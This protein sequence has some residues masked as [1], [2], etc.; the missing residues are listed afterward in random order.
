[1]SNIQ[2]TLQTIWFTSQRLLIYCLVATQMWHCFC[3]NNTHLYVCVYVC[4]ICVCVC[5]YVCMYMC[6]CMYVCMCIMY[7]C[8]YVC[9]CVYVCVYVCMYVYYVCMYVCL[10]IIMYVCMYMYYVCMYVRMYVY[11][12]VCTVGYATTNQCYNEQFLSIKSGCYN[13]S[14]GI[15]VLSADVARAC[16]WH[17]EA[18]R[19]DY[20]VSHHPCY[21]L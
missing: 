16:A 6:V 2:M 18:S 9:I 5:V 7:V 4:I 17:V 20:S 13:E 12:Y 10:C 14:E 1:M 8:M 11:M 15:P 21:R 19:F 3:L